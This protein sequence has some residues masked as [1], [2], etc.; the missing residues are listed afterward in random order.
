MSH[1]VVV[2]VDGS[3]HSRHALDHAFEAARRVGAKV[4]VVHAYQVPMPVP[5]YGVP[6]VTTRTRDDHERAARGVL[7]QT[8]GT[9]PR[10]LDIECIVTPRPPAP[11]LVRLASGADLLVVGSRG[12]GGFKQLLLGSTSHQVV[13]HA[14]CPVLVVPAVRD[15]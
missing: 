9:H 5:L 10:D 2:G 6:P 3:D 8:V 11:A 13:T 14:T 7:D 12:R 1:R 15:E 4:T